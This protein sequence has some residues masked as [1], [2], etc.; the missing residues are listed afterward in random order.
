M[1][2]SININLPQIK[3]IS[4][5]G[6]RRTSVFLGLGVNAA[7]DEKVK[8]YQL[9]NL[10]SLRFM[11][12]NL[13]DD[14]ISSF[15]KQFEHWVISCGL[16]ELTET[17]SNFLSAIYQACLLNEIYTNNNIIDNPNKL[18]KSF[19]W[20][21]VEKQLKLLRKKFGIQTTKEKYLITINR[22]RNC[23][24]HRSGIV[25]IEDLRSEEKSFKICWWAFKVF[26][27]TP[28]GEKIT[29]KPPMPKEG[30]YLKDGGNVCLQ[31][32]EKER[33][34]QLKEVIIL[35]P[36]ELSEICYLLT[37]GTNEI[38]NST[39]EYFKASGVEINETEPNATQGPANSAGL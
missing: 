9:Q 25:G 10:T 8:N 35:S 12:D 28:S 7:R 31:F 11:P 16:R 29:L 24:T 13:D 5:K 39:F 36:N 18:I 22:V 1:T 38:T 30:I 3:E 19:K 34:F 2:Q 4:L 37:D 6:I 33:E 14:Q 21:G 32:L 15:K 26:I 17:F 27:E 23:I 20:M